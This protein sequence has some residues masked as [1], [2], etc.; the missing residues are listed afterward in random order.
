MAE[1]KPQ[2]KDPTL[3][4]VGRSDTARVAGAVGHR[5]REPKY[6]T[7]TQRW[8]FEPKAEGESQHVAESRSSATDALDDGWTDD[9]PASEAPSPPAP[10]A[11]DATEVEDERPVVAADAVEAVALPPVAAIAEAKT[12]E[13]VAPPPVVPITKAKAEPVL[14]PAN[15]HP[16]RP[17]PAEELAPA[18]PERPRSRA[19]WGALIALLIV[20]GAAGMWW[21]RSTPRAVEATTPPTV[22]PAASESARSN[23]TTAA[24]GAAAGT[25]ASSAS[26]PPTEATPTTAPAASAPSPDPTAPFDARSADHALSATA[27]TIANCRHGKIFGAGRATV[28]FGNDGAV[29]AC[30]LP[31][32]FAGTATG[33]CVTDAL[34]AVRVPPFRGKPKPVAHRFV[35][36]PK[37]VE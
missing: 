37:R 1:E 24:T 18:V 20:G 5:D 10:S 35:V 7:E 9:P 33:A 11:D 28:T 29:S 25:P 3:V 30:V 34:S 12:V 14:E 13:A 17:M 22:T 26:A 19:P 21:R 36:A 27:K 2:P 16:D 31:T 6:A 23:S 32:A 4:G 15:V 8:I